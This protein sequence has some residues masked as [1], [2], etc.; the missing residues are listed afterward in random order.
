[1]PSPAP[2]LCSTRITPL[3]LHYDRG[4]RSKSGVRSG[5]RPQRA[6]L[7]ASAQRKRLVG[8]VKAQI[9]GRVRRPRLGGIRNLPP[10]PGAV[11]GAFRSPL[12][13]ICSCACVLQPL[14]A[15]GR[16][17]LSAARRCLRSPTPSPS[18]GAP[19]VP[20]RYATP[21]PRWGGLRLR[22]GTA[23]VGGRFALAYA[24]ASRHPSV[25]LSLGRYAPS[26]CFGDFSVGGL[27]N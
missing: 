27:Q 7:S 14:R 26:G 5:L 4:F 19:L 2:S 16:C 23:V 10:P 13:F 1:M 11:A 17:P 21:R 20:L 15:G 9:G 3:W 12:L 8:G 24:R 18:S 25:F 22:L 6:F